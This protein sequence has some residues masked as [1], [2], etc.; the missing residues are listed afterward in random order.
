VKA[1]AGLEAAASI[2]GKYVTQ[3]EVTAAAFIQVTFGNDVRG[4]PVSLD[5]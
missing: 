4:G 2:T 3:V 1:K 5:S